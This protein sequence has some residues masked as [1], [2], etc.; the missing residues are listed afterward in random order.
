MEG[1]FFY[2]FYSLSTLVFLSLL[3][4][5]GVPGGGGV[6]RRLPCQPPL[7]VVAGHQIS[8]GGSSHHG[9]SGSGLH[10]VRFDLLRREMGR[11]FLH[12]S[13]FDLFRLLLDRAAAEG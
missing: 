8:L 11:E 10:F 13:S 9:E 5:L 2:I 3:S 4:K 12:F 6:H 7:S 1:S